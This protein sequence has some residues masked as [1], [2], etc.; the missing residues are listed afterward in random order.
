MAKCLQTSMLCMFFPDISTLWN[1]RTLVTLEMFV[2]VLLPAGPYIVYFGL[3][4]K[5]EIYSNWSKN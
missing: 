5:L 2:A 3:I 4:K 1:P